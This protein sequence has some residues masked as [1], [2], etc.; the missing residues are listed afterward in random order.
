[1]FMVKYKYND[2]GHLSIFKIGCMYSALL[3]IN[4]VKIFE[5]GSGHFSDI[6]PEV[7]IIFGL[8]KVGLS[9][10][11]KIFGKTWFDIRQNVLHIF[12]KCHYFKT[13]AI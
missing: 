10:R 7:S 3:C 5:I 11:A 13:H 6:C 12:C 9:G 1:M 8:G 2:S 4:F